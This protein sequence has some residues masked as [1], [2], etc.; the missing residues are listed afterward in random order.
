[1]SQFNVDFLMFKKINVN[2][3]ETDPIF[4]YLRFNSPLNEGN[5]VKYLQWNFCKFLLDRDGKVVEYYEPLVYPLELKKDI[6]KLL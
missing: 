3:D 5:K 6:D 2:G 4:K 1:M